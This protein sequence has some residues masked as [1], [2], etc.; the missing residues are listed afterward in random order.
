MNN[1]VENNNN[2]SN[3]NDLLLNLN[4]SKLKFTEKKLVQDIFE[5][6]KN[7]NALV[8]KDDLFVFLLS[9]I[10][11]YEFYLIKVNKNN[12]N[13]KEILEEVLKKKINDEEVSIIK[14]THKKDINSY[15]LSRVEEKFVSSIVSTR[16]YVG[17]D[18]QNKAIITLQ[19]AQIIHKDFNFLS[20]NNSNANHSLSKKEKILKP[21]LPFRPTTNPNSDKLSSNF[22][23][24][25]QIVI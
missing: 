24:K 12:F 14:K 16:K 2:P 21:N 18:N 15:I 1:S 22:R 10:N 7:E 3:N 11:L 23:R 4:E 19:M 25:I 6:L 13:E 17:F 5:N 8:H 9:V 20:I